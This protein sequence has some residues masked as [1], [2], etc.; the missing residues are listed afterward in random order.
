LTGTYEE[1]K[2][3]YQQPCNQEAHGTTTEI[4]YK[5]GSYNT[6]VIIMDIIANEITVTIREI[7]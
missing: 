6:T 7:R 2:A 1:E 5:H 3:G 4:N